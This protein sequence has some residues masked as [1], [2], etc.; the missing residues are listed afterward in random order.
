MTAKRKNE[1][2]EKEIPAAPAPETETAEETVEIKNTDICFDCPHCGHNLVIDFRGAGLPI[3]CVNCGGEVLVPIPGGMNADD[4][5]LDKGDILR[6]LFATRRNLQRA[7]RR[8]ARLEERLLN[9]TEAL[10]R[11]SDV[12]NAGADEGENA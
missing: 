4:L 2:P 8:A 12:L 11:V 1:E 7:E 9:V 5:D 3:A 10:N 6:E